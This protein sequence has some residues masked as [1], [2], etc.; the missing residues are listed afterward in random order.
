MS[1]LA[2]LNALAAAEAE[3]DLL[4]CCGSHEWARRV[5]ALRPFDSADALFDAAEVVWWALDREDWL[6][7]FRSHPRIGEKKAE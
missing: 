2:R 5:A 4:T 6:Q 3:A 1:G 7:A